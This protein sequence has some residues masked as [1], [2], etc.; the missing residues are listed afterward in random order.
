M[1]V[2]ASGDGALSFLSVWLSAV[3][4]TARTIGAAHQVNIARLSVKSTN[5]IWAAES[6]MGFFRTYADKH[7]N[8]SSDTP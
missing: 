3:T 5:S 7:D 6:Q 1:D 8:L 2:L 4:N